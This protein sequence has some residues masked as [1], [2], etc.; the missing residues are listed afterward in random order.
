MEDYA[1]EPA[2]KQKIDLRLKAIALQW[3][4]RKAIKWTE[5][6]KAEVERRLANNILRHAGDKNI[7]RISKSDL[8]SLL[9]QIE[10]RGSFNLAKV[11]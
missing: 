4:A 3:L 11:S 10:Q 8:L 6:H 2:N 7:Q 1:K 9:Q 5:A